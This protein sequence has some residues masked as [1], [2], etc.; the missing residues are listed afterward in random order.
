MRRFLFRTVSQ[1]IVSYH[2][3]SLSVGAAGKLRPGDR[4]PWVPLESKSDNFAPLQSLNWQAHVYG[5]ASPRLAEACAP[6]QLPLHVFK[7]EAKMQRLGFLRDA[8]YLVRPDGYIG[9][10]DGSADPQKLRDYWATYAPPAVSRPDIS[11]ESH[12]SNPHH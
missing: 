1:L 3:S 5:K 8:V 9:L 2:H 12:P 11:R 6:L 10:I 4:L 7:W